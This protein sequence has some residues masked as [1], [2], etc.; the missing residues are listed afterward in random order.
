VVDD[1]FQRARVRVAI[2]RL[3]IERDFI[4]SQVK[5]AQAALSAARGT[6]S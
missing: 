2:N 6:V 1:S 5:V 4:E 3:L